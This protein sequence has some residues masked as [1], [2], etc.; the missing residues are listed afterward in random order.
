LREQ[1]LRKS[2]EEEVRQKLEQEKIQINKKSVKFSEQHNKTVYIKSNPSKIKINNDLTESISTIG[3]IIKDLDISE[4]SITPVNNT[5]TVATS[6]KQKKEK[7]TE[8][9]EMMRVALAY[10]ITHPET[11]GGPTVSEFQRD[12]T[13]EKEFEKVASFTKPRNQI[14]FTPQTAGTLATQ[15]NACYGCGILIKKHDSRLCEYTGKWH[16]KICHKKDIYYIPG[17]I[18]STWDF[19]KYPVSTS[20]K[21]FLEIMK[22]EPLFDIKAINPNLFKISVLLTAKETR[23]LMNLMKEF[24][25][26]CT[27]EKNLFADTLGSR[28]HLVNSVN[29][30]SLTDLLELH[31]G[32]LFD[33]LKKTRE[34]WTTHF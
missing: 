34:R 7:V 25:I 6:G 1:F 30:Y 23:E 17:K 31:S 12:D 29:L 24:A 27:R 20:A 15:N 14:F 9:E 11:A 19:K 13:I 2:I 26:T 16:C 22:D 33:L 10:A 3:N 21:E 5:S 28:I 18:L 8:E 4:K 32:D